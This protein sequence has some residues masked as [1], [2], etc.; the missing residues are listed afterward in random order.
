MKSYNEVTNNLLER[1]T[2][3]VLEQNIKKKRIIGVITSLSCCCLVAL[4]CFGIWQ[5][6]IL[7]NKS[8]IKLGN[9]FVGNNSEQQTANPNGLE[10]TDKTIPIAA[11]WVESYNNLEELYSEADFIVYANVLE[12]PENID[13]GLGFTETKIKIK[14]VLKGEIPAKE[15]V[16]V[17]NGQINPDGTEYSVEGIPLLKKNMKVILFLFKNYQY[18]EDSQ[19]KEFAYHVLAPLPGKFIFDKDMKLHYFSE[20]L[21]DSSNLPVSELEKYSGFTYEEF[22]KELS[23]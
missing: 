3:Y 19:N 20:L 5:S 15:I 17:E 21:T 9:A 12:N 2:R 14:E 16:V 7:G 1:R 6:G 22:K 8:P 13:K 11:E 18:Y 4:F 10:K 23:K